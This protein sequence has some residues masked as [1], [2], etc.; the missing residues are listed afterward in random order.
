MLT[1]VHLKCTTMER[2]LL[3][4]IITEQRNDFLNKA[5]GVQREKLAEAEHYLKLPHVYV[6][7][8]IRRCGK[9]TLMR[10]IAEK[11]FPANDFF[12]LNFEDERLFNFDVAHFNLLL[13]T[14][15]EMYGPH[16]TFVIDEIQNLENFE[17]AV[18]R[19]S[20]AG[21]KFIIS[22]S[23]AELLSGEFSTKITGR[24]VVTQLQPFCF[25][26]FLKFHKAE[27]SA[28]D[29]YLTEK[30]AM[31]S[32][33]F[34]KYFSDGGMPE[35]LTYKTAEILIRMY[36]DILIKDIAVRH[37]ISN[38]VQ[39]REL[40][41]YLI[42]NFGRR[43]SYHSLRKATGLGSVNTAINYAGFL[44][45]SFLI[46]NISK[47]DY[48]LK[49]QQLSEKKVYVSD[50]AIIRQ[51]STTLMKDTGRILENM[52]ANALFSSHQVFYFAGKHEC[53]FVA[54]DADQNIK[55]FQVCAYLNDQNTARETEGLLEAMKYFNLQ[56]GMI[57]TS[58]QEEDNNVDNK[59]IRVMPVW[60]WLLNWK[61]TN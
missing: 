39:L 35:Y 41:R 14:Q 53:D 11:Y 47:F 54:V 22:G 15:I 48:S 33:Y 30:R 55:L 44:E 7:S 13:E 45:Q 10:Q 49:V 8:G 26:E 52:V 57:L 37:G 43:F 9:S 34:E 42:T 1:F 27:F 59:I 40:S 5:T 18:R 28:E 23:N 24:Q 31:L 17:L 50:H 4:Q 3:K 20:D 19:L 46:R 12:F 36:E 38:V 16:R 60:K 61:M 32:A 6:I 21:Y 58:S 2:E 51:V 29:L 25:T 56:E